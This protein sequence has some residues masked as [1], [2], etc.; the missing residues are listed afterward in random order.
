MNEKELIEELLA[1][2]CILHT[3]GL[4]NL[5]S[6]RSISYI[7]EFFNKR[8][9]WETGQ[10]II[11]N[12]FEDDKQFKNPALNKVIKYKTVN[13]DDAEG[14][15]GNLLRRPDTED[16]YK[17][18]VATLGGE[19]SD[20]YKKAMDDLGGEGQPDR[21]IEGEREKKDD[22]G[23]GEEPETGT[24]FDPKTKGGAA[25][26]KG[27]PD[28]DPAKPKSMKDDSE[29]TLSA[30]GVVYPVGGGYYADTPGGKPKYREATEEGVDKMDFRYILENDDEGKDVVKKIADTGGETKT[31]TVIGDEEKEKYKNTTEQIQKNKQKNQRYLNNTKG[32]TSTQNIN[33]IDGPNKENVLNAKEKVPGSP[34]S[35]VAEVGVGYGMAC[36]SENE[37]DIKK[38]DECLQNKLKETKLGEQFNTKELR[39]GALQGARRELIKVG[40]LIEEEGLNAETTTTGHVGGSKDSL[41]NTVKSLRDKGVTEVNGIPIDEY[42]KIILAGGGGDNP[43]DTMVVVVDQSSGKSFIYHTSN[44]MTSADQISNGS[45]SKEIDEIGSIASENY[46]ETQKKELETA[47][48]ET[49][50]NIQKHRNNQKEYIRKQ[51]TKMA[52]DANNPEIARRAIDRLKGVENPVSTSGDKYWK[53]LIGH[54][55]VKDF[56]KEKGYDLKNL[57]PEQEVEAY[58]HYTNYMQSADPETERKDGGV[59]DD[60]IQIITRLYGVFGNPKRNQEEFTTGKPPK[61]P[62]FDEDELNSFYDKQTD[63]LNTLREKMNAIKEGSGDVAFSKRMKKRLHLDIAEGKNP[64]GIPNDKFETVMGEYAYKDLKQDSDGN[65]YQQDKK[66]KKFYLVNSDGSLG[67][68]PFDGKLQDLDVA[69]VADPDTIKKCLGLNEGDSIEDGIEIRVDLY[70]NRKVIIYDK[71]GKQVGFQSARSKTGPGGP[72]QDTIAYHPDFQKCLAKQT[73][74]M[75]K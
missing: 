55:S 67:K 51:Q 50:D 57:T 21:D 69:V 36:L 26:L 35:A 6:E 46:D 52:D 40:K 62:V 18:A 47:Q 13:G 27:L 61:E 43:T 10:M 42:E 33:E 68:T 75:G 19:D 39:K 28:T 24:A 16:A 72:M 30:G 20:T 48:Q 1:D 29:E 60:D 70:N 2:L 56:A 66:T 25:Y 58:Q 49:K 8:G 44:K 14:K 74:L 54:K 12:L 63:E 4:P 31:L 3:D 45:P 32:I 71:D 41:S 9:M 23:G 38:A 5:Q 11:E 64:G 22:A 53:K 73:V 65:L 15:V 34:S 59:G 17:K 7:S 37:F